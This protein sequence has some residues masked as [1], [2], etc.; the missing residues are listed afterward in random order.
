MKGIHIQASIASI[1]MRAGP[2]MREEGGRLPAEFAGEPRQRAEAVLHQ[3]LADHP[4]DGD[5]AQHERH[6]EGD[7]EEL[8]RP[9]VGVEQQCQAEGDRVFDQHRQ[10]VEDHVGER[11]PVVGVVEHLDEV[12]EVV[13][14]RTRGGGQVPVQRADVEA[15][16]RREDGDGH[17][18]E[19]G[20]QHE[21]RPEPRFAA[22]H[23][24]A[25][26]EARHPTRRRRR[27]SAASWRSRSGRRPAASSAWRTI[28]R[29]A[30]RSTS[31]RS[32]PCR[33]PRGRAR[34][35]PR[36]PRTR[37]RSRAAEKLCRPWRAFRSLVR[38]PV[39]KGRKR[40]F[41]QAEN[42]PGSVS[43]RRV[44]C[45]HSGLQ[46]QPPATCRALPCRA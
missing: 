30:A 21:E 32:A 6:E 43:R 25:E 9:D 34:P 31:A 12:A 1:V 2:G 18:E 29:H 7:A 16:Q 17:G 3:R 37:L 46:G 24:L 40:P 4:A 41:R 36:P 27:A 35:P 15:E 22:D 14:M 23:H 5:R 38:R 26:A 19:S 11:V 44:R 20:R 13:E 33:S 8:A 10:H 39:S 42:S 28:D 45:A